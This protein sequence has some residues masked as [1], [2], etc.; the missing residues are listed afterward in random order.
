MR[1]QYANGIC[2]CACIAV[3]VISRSNID[4]A[5]EGHEGREIRVRTNFLNEQFV[6]D[7]MLTNSHIGRGLW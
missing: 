5:T 3:T 7:W 1:S 2:I 6:G 4:V